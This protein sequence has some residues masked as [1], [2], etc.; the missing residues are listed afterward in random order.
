MKQNAKNKILW[1]LKHRHEYSFN[2]GARLSVQYDKNGVNGIEAFYKLDSE[3]KLTP[4]KHPNILQALFVA[5]GSL[6][7]NIQMWAQSRA[8]GSL[9]LCMFSKRLTKE[10]YKTENQYLPD[11]DMETENNLPEYVVN[12]VE[13]QKNKFYS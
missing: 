4:T 5:K 12:A 11:T 6:N 10:L 9:P 2:G 1:L 13:Q 8:E 7:L 3:G